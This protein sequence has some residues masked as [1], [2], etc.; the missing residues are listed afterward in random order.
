MSNPVPSPQLLEF[1]RA[2]RAYSSAAYQ[3]AAA[4]EAMADKHRNPN[5]DDEDFEVS[6]HFP[7]SIKTSFD[8][9]ASQ[10]GHWYLRVIGEVP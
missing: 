9:H 8:E 3:L 6:K 4:W 5:A 2:L 10:V 1:E 7:D